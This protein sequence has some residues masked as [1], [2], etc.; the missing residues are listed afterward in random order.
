MQ[1]EGRTYDRVEDSELLNAVLMPPGTLSH[2]LAD[3][4]NLAREEPAVLV[5]VSASLGER[6]GLPARISG[7]FRVDVVD[8]ERGER[9]IVARLRAADCEVRLVVDPLIEEVVGWVR[10]LTDGRLLQM[11]LVPPERWNA[12]TFRG[13]PSVETCGQTGFAFTADALP[14][15]SSARL[16]ALLAAA[17]RL[18]A[19]DALPD[20]EDV[21]EVFATT[22]LPSAKRPGRSALH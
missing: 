5:Y 1:I 12:T 6:L 15:N 22:L 20:A 10:G 2:R 4:L 16:P 9:F 18:R 8:F 17:I 7:R 13:V 21:Q 11:T 19:P 14:P 3:A